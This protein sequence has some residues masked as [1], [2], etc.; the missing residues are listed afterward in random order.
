MVLRVFVEASGV[1]STVEIRTSSGFERL[2]K[3]ALAAVSRWKFVPAKQGTDTV[4]AWVLVPIV[5]SL[6]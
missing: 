1:P 6:K 2:D 3:S 4:G 5:F